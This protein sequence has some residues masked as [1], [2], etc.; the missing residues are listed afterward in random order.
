MV[1]DPP[2]V[3]EPLH[4]RHPALVTCQLT[5]RASAGALHPT[6]SSLAGLEPL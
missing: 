2:D 6:A 4:S 3:L 5:L 1:D